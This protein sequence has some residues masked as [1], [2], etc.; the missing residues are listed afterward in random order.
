MG[1]MAVINRRFIRNLKARFDPRI[2]SNMQLERFLSINDAY[3][4]VLN[5]SGWRDQDKEGS[6]YR[7]YFATC[8]E[9]VVS[10]HPGDSIRGVSSDADLSIDLLEKPSEKLYRHFDCILNHTVL[11]HVRYP[12]QAIANLCDMTAKD[13]I[14]VVPFIQ[15]LHFQPGQYGDYFRF[16]PMGLREMLAENSF[17]TIYEDVG[18]PG[19]STQYIFSVS[20]RADTSSRCSDNPPDL[21]ETM[22]GRTG[23]IKS[24]DLLK[25]LLSRA[26]VSLIRRLERFR[27]RK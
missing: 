2:W 18:P 22:N 12:E 1:L 27:V 25:E 15:H 17:E 19:N 10:N 13:L 20:R 14:I 4:K 6:T 21:L 26:A 3:G 7:N 9:Y 16:T 23:L 5:A 11:E 24:S 8:T